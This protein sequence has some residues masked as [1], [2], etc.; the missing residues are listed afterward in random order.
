MRHAPSPTQTDVPLASPALALA[1]GKLPEGLYAHVQ[2]VRAIARDLAAPLDLDPALVD[3]AAAAHDIARAAKGP[4]LLAEA[5]QMGLAV[6]PPDIN[7]SGRK[8][9]VDGESRIIF[10]L[11]AIKHVGQKAAD[12][13]KSVRKQ[14]S[15]WRTLPAFVADIDLQTVNRKALECLV[16]S[17]ACD[18]LE[19]T[20]RQKFVG[21]E[22]AIKYAQAVQSGANSNQESLF[23]GSSEVPMSMEP[24]L[25]QVDAWT[26]DELFE[27]EKALTGFYLT[28][29]PLKAFEDDLAEFS[30][31]G[32]G[33]SP[34]HPLPEQLRLGGLVT[35]LKTHQTRKGTTMA[36]FTLEG[37]AGRVE[38]VVF[39]DLFSRV[40]PLLRNEAKVFV[41]GRISERGR[42]PD[43]GQGNGR[44]ASNGYQDSTAELKIVAE[45]IVPLEELRRTAKRI[46]L[47]LSLSN[48]NSEL[49]HDIRALS[50][51]HRGP[52]ELWLHI[53]DDTRPGG[54]SGP[55]RRI[56]STDCRVTAA[57][58]YLSDLR[59]LIGH[60]N[61]W[62]ST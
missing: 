38:V 7:H 61:V 33:N 54:Q 12:H 56:R 6:L 43:N 45:D 36:F 16:Q 3:L 35:Q 48:L 57:K 47:K 58:G 31:Y 30:N 28:G 15:G 44:A 27:M 40:Q 41:T 55:L 11:N 22:D 50:D 52:C 32:S 4:Q 2:R 19:G 34:P 29:H 60:D 21:L 8:F 10:G 59:G 26:D 62:L 14:N 13:V 49:I 51:R 46:N 53:A 23:G 24:A 39:S 20:R 37:L 1:L 9:R 42:P 18:S 25:P 17:G 5:R